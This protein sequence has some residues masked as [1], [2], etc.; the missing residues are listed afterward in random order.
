[1]NQQK[2]AQNP[3]INAISETIRS[4]P[5]LTLLLLAAVIGTIIMSVLPPLV[6][7]AAV[8]RLSDGLSVSFKLALLYFIISA[9]ANLLECG[10]NILITKFG[11]R[12]TREIRRSMCQKLSALPAQYF[13]D[14][15]PGTISSRFVNDVD[16]LEDLFASG[17]ISIIVDICKVAAILLVIFTKSLG[18]GIL[19]LVA[20][21]LI[22]LFTRYVQKRMLAAQL[23]SRRAVGMANRHIP[24]SIRNIRTVRNLRAQDFMEN[25]YSNFIEDGYAAMEESNFYDAIYSPII[26]TLSSVIVAVMMCLTAGGRQMAAYFGMGVGTVVAVIAYVG[27]VFDPLESIGMEIQNIQS[28][29]AGIERIKEFLNEAEQPLR[30]ASADLCDDPA[31]KISGLSFS[32]DGEHE[33]LKNLDITVVS[34]E[35]VTLTGRTGA[36]KSTVFKLILGLYSPDAG[37]VKIL[38]RE[39]DT[40]K[41]EERSRYIGYV[42]QN[43]APVAGSL[44]DQVSLSDPEITEAEIRAALDTVGLLQAVDEMPEGLS[45]RY[46]EE[47]LS[48]GQNQ[49]LSIARAIVRRPCILLLDEITA[50]LDSATEELVMNAIGRAMENRTVLSISHRIYEQKGGR[51]IAL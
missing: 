7:E 10:K 34:G 8:D 16:T 47:L 25:K 3:I 12:T 37:S 1:M 24:E 50:G 14:N 35:Q 43:F 13:V 42:E 28:A 38:G 27:K 31:V 23:K 9:A 33:I 4:N 32:Y 51:M 39:A 40:W 30:E 17:V 22:Y 20:V 2:K 18:L 26:I 44:G 5:A 11:Q 15:A 6:L 19:M 36:G 46:S 29:A 49:L 21:P 41:P 45:T 48:H